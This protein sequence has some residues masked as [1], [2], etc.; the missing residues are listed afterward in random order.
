MK[1][2]IKLVRQKN[3][4]KGITLI[5]LAI[6]IVILLILSGVSILAITSE[7]GL[8]DRAK[9]AKEKTLIQEGKEK[10]ELAITE[11][12][13]EKTVN[14]ENLSK[15]DLSKINNNEIKV[16]DIGDFPV[17]AIYKNYIY[18][19]D[20]NFK[21]IYVSEVGDIPKTKPKE[22]YNLG[23]ENS[24]FTVHKGIPDYKG[25]TEGVYLNNCIISR[26]CELTVPYTIILESKNLNV[27]S[28]Q[29]GMIF[30]FGYGGA[31]V[32]GT[33]LGV[34]L[35]GDTLCA[36]TGSG[37]GY[38]ISRSFSSLYRSNE[39]NIL[40]IKYDGIEFSFFI[41]ENKVG[42]SKSSSI[43]NTPLYI[44]G[45]SNADTSSAGVNWGY[46]NGYCRNLKIYDCAL[47]DEEITR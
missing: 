14:E 44:G 23:E 7:N 5:S 15:D 2:V 33:S 40:A 19:I 42:T 32:G 47:L 13:A 34:F 20:E 25:K 35:Y 37:D 38:S 3:K 16:E 28:G 6:T 29:W 4:E 18:N 22:E 26:E 10:I 45:F 43:K 46:A 1:K 27:P 12:I 41:N 30:G 39:W 9:Q 17:E 36:T 24:V 21:V 11:L 8:F 31:G